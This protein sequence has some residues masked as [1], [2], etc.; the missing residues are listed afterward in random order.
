MPDDLGCYDEEMK[1]KVRMYGGNDLGVVSHG[2]ICKECGR[3]FSAPICTYMEMLKVCLACA[4]KK[5][6]IP[7]EALMAN[8]L[9]FRITDEARDLGRIKK[10]ERKIVAVADGAC[11]IA[12]RTEHMAVRSTMRRKIEPSGA[13][14]RGDVWHVVKDMEAENKSLSWKL[15]NANRTVKWLAFGGIVWIVEFFALLCFC[16]W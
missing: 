13:P 16:V 7:V 9:P 10:V 4:E 14:Y 5:T 2:I 15:E 6:D 3:S 12:Q 8:D 11:D 1:K